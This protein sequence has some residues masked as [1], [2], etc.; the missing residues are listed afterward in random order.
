MR[1]TRQMKMA[2][3]SAGFCAAFLSAALAFADRGGPQAGDLSART[4]PS[5]QQALDANRG[6]MVFVPAG[7][8]TI[9]EKIRIRGDHSGLFGPG[10][11]IQ[12]NTNAP[13][14]EIEGAAGVQVRDLTLTRPE[15]KMEVPCEAVVAIKCRDLVLEN[16]RVLDNRTRSSAI[17]VRECAG[18]QIRG[19]LVRNYMRISVDDRTGSADWGYAFKCIDGTGIEVRHSRGTLI[20]GNRVI[21]TNLLPTPEVQ[22]KFDLGRFVK[23]NATKGAIASQ[24]AWDAGFAQNW[25]QGSAIIVTAPEVSDCTQILGNYIENAAQGIDLH[26]DHV[27]VAQ[28]IINNSFMGMKAMHGS[29]HVL[30]L[31]NQFIKNDL[32]SIGLMPGAASHA[33][34]PAR[35]GKPPVAA[36]VDGGSIIAH[37]IISDFGYGHAHWI[38]GDNGAPLR[39]DR[40]QKPD[41]PPLT[42]VIIEGNMVYDTGRDQVIVDGQPKVEPPRYKYAVIV[43]T[44]GNGPRGLHFSNNLFHPGTRGVSN[45][46][47]KP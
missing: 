7:D 42:D 8:Y 21:E 14:I 23:K 32:W 17:A 27:I 19:C 16:L 26:S 41:N 29:R 44:G 38:W 39:F 3:P 4:Y 43:E 2:R 47:L 34:A 33:A 13:I 25:H 15:G 10:R 12:T 24:Q 11:I 6:R 9:S 1:E 40:G 5:I 46:E 20:Q 30:I 45:V 28:N 22:K 18:S 37:N 35:D 36:N 31:G